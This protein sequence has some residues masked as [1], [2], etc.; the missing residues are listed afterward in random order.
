MKPGTW[1][2]CACWGCTGTALS[3]SIH[4]TLLHSNSTTL[5]PNM[6]ACMPSACMHAY[7]W[8]EHVLPGP[9]MPSG[10][11]NIHIVAAAESYS[12]PHM[13]HASWHAQHLHACCGVEQVLPA[14]HMPSMCDELRR[15]QL[16]RA[17]LTHAT[18][19]RQDAM[20]AACRVWGSL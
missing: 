16:Q 19:S 7:S 18:Q 13:W 9:R 6:Q 10:C 8:G 15:W 4:F 2:D 12:P 5:L 14:P 11:G 17:M 1:A 3:A 20:V